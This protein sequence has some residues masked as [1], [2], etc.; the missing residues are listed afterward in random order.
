MVSTV[1]PFENCVC[2]VGFGSDSDE[3]ENDLVLGIDLHLENDDCCYGELDCNTR[4][5][6]RVTATMI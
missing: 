3:D 5:R 4:L 6:L 1:E 2:V